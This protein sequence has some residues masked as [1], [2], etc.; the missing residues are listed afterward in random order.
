MSTSDFYDAMTPFYHLIYPNWEESSS[1][2]VALLD[3]IIHDY[4]G[5]QVN[6]ILDVSCGI[7]TQSLGLAQLGYQVTAS[8]LSAASITRAKAEAQRRHL[9][10]R[11]SVADMRQ[12]FRHHEQ[13]FDLVISCDNAVPHLLSDDD[14]R[15]ALEQFYQCTRPGGGSLI[16][17]RDYAQEMGTGV[18]VQPYGV[19]D[20]QGTRYLVF[21]VREWRG[22]H[23][24]V[25]MY[26][27]ADRGGTACTT[28][29][30]RGQYY[31]VPID[32]LLRLMRAAGFVD[33][34]RLDDRYVQPIL[35]DRKS[36]A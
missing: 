25:A 6:S 15:Q 7:G 12:V 26:F 2:Q 11:F 18:E 36:G 4:W 32:R 24:D 28:Q 16:S 5:D 22:A 1:R 3:T 27:V 10:I 13:Q 34:Q 30:T 29:V 17:V 9:A 8:D 33:V 35:M 14:I 21:Q 20:D 23:Y 31:A 19:R